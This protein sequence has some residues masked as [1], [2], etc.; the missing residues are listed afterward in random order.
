MTVQILSGFH[1]DFFNGAYILTI[2]KN[3]DETFVWKMNNESIHFKDVSE[4]VEYMKLIKTIFSY[5]LS[6]NFNN[7]IVIKLPT[8]PKFTI[9]SENFAH[10]LT[11]NN[12][13]LEKV[14]TKWYCA[15]DK[16]N[17]SEV[18]YSSMPNLI[19]HDPLYFYPG[20]STTIPDIFPH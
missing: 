19:P 10:F 9:R 7:E 6:S 20:E 8:L 15:D 1:I 14:L 11:A 13:L 12:T 5:G 16:D 4:V 2:K 18:S 3:L 17:E